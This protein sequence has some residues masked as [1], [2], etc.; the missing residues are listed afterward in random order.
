MYT[1]L[2]NDII[3]NKQL[4]AYQSPSGR[5]TFNKAINKQSFAYFTPIITAIVP[6][7][8]VTN[9]TKT[10]ILPSIARTLSTTK[11]VVYPKYLYLNATMD[12][13]MDYEDEEDQDNMTRLLE[14]VDK[15]MKPVHGSYLI[16]ISLNS[17]E[18]I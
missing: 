3:S 8:V 6:I 7:D 11:A 14:Y 1:P 9:T 17:F 5:V 4:D 18:T 10:H 13:Y 15:K 16:S 12:E 2:L